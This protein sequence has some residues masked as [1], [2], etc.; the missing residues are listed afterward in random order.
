MQK[1]LN[2]FKKM[3]TDSDML[4]KRFTRVQASDLTKSKFKK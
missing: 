3:S 4:C 1:L 2:V